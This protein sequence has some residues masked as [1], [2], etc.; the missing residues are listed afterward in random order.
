[1][2]KA[3]YKKR[4]WWIGGTVTSLLWSLLSIGGASAAMMG[5]TIA[6]TTNTF[7]SGTLVLNALTGTTPCT[8]TTSSVST[9]AASCTGSTLPS[10]PL[11]TSPVSASVTLSSLGTLAPSS[12]RLTTSTCGEQQASTTTGTDTALAYGNVTY[13]VAGPLGGTAVALGA[14]SG[15]FDT[16][17]TYTGPN[18]FTQVAWFKTTSSGSIFS[19]ENTYAS[20]APSTW[21]RMIWI[22]ATGHVVAGVYP[23]AVEEISSPN[24]YNDGLWHFVAVT[25]NAASGSTLGFRLYVDGSLV[26]SSTAVTSAQAYSGY[27]HIGWSNAPSGWTD[28]PS[29]AYF[30]GSLAGVGV[31]P[32]ALSATSIAALYA[33]ASLNAYSSSVSGDAPTA[34]WPLND[35]GTVAYTGAVP[36]VTSACAL[37]QVTIQATQGATTTCVAPAKVGA[38]GVPTSAQTL[39]TALSDAT[40]NAA[41]SSPVTLTTSMD[42]A[43]GLATNARG[44]RLVVPVT[45]YEQVGSFSATLAYSMGVV[46][47]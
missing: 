37:D 23:N 35:T 3:S 24:T 43:A 4:Q 16:I 32:S 44:L 36:G 6:D 1:M 38:C 14:A 13:S 5:A 47:L 18:I 11:S 8:S 21:D 25:L 9:N 26:A 45:Y 29:N 46:I 20:T 39:A 42:V 22:D 2:I 31:L 15:N 41:R 19:F 28:P 27:W 17:S 30:T 10:G 7:S 33:S 34:Y 12:S 40:P